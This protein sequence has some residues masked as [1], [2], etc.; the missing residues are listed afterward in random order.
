MSRQHCPACVATMILVILAVSVVHPCTDIFITKG[1]YKT[2]VRTF[3]LDKVDSKVVINP[4]GIS[5]QSSGLAA[6][7]VPLKWTSLYGCV[8]V[9]AFDRDG[10]PEGMNEHGLSCANLVLAETK[11]PPPDSRPAVNYSHW[12]QYFLDTCKTVA[13]AVNEAPKLR[14]GPVLVGGQTWPLHVV[15]HDASGDSA[16]LEYLDG[17]LRIHHPA[18]VNVLTNSPPYESQLQNLKR[19][20]GFGG[21]EGLPGDIDSRSR[22][23]RGAY[24]LKILPEALSSQ[25]SVANAFSL[26]QTV[27]QPAGSAIPSLWTVVRDHINKKCYFRTLKSPVVKYVDFDSVDFSSGF[28]SAVEIDADICGEM[29]RYFRPYSPNP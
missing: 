22:F 18:E 24:F 29:S 7:D 3:D 9:N 1:S 14:V 15:L 20:K 6:E 19:Y 4:R 8:T 28:Q 21:N 16:I 13:E 10:G 26:I 11:Y 12:V 5:R 23:V 2:S 17:E 27:A 25:D